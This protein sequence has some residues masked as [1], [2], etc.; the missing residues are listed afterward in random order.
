MRSS[1]RAALKEAFD[2][3]G[4][5]RMATFN[6]DRKGNGTIEVNVVVNDVVYMNESQIHRA[7]KQIKDTLK[8]DVRLAVEQIKVQP[9][10]L[11]DEIVKPAIQPVVLPPQK[12]SAEKSGE[13]IRTIVRQA[14]NR[15]NDIISPSSITGYTVAFNDKA[16]TVSIELGIKRD[17]KLPEEQ[18]LWLQRIYSEELNLPIE[19]KI[20]M[21]PFVRP[22]IFEKGKT[23]LTADMQK[24][25]IVL[26]D[27]FAN[28]RSLFITVNSYPESSLP[29]RKRIGLAEE[30]A[31]TVK[32]ILI[33]ECKI[34]ETEITIV[35]HKREPV[36]DP[37]V[38]IEVH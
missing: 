17:I 12:P 11:K 9:G 29:Y 32:A 33:N 21:E 7:E 1:I 37:T 2:V 34:A 20:N 30:R 35:I 23:S 28:N 13:E 5:S 3:E 27:V 15:I 36:N 26:K 18:K 31:K 4:S 16:A 19:L 6:Y 10:G 8:Y 22:L 25:I 24:E 38:R 14:N